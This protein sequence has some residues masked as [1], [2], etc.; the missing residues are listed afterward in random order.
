[1]TIL[2]CLNSTDNIDI[3]NL[4]MKGLIN[5]GFTIKVRLHPYMN[6]DGLD[7]SKVVVSTEQSFLESL[8][9]MDLVIAGDSSVHLEA[10][11]AN[12]PSF[13][14]STYKIYDYYGY[15][16]NKLVVWSGSS[17]E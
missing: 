4:L 15:S 11:A 8:N 13:Y 9:N 17:I 2:V 14:F 10:T 5:A 1:K 7:L 12:I 3:F 6:P 16:E